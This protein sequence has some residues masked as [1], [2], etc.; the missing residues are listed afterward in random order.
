MVFLA[1]AASVGLRSATGPPPNADHPVEAA[2]H[3]Q[4]ASADGRPPATR[5][6]G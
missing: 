3:I 5:T 4:L 6:S 2:Q 1:W